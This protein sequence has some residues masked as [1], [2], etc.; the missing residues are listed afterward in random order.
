[1]LVN[2]VFFWRNTEIKA[3]KTCILNFKYKCLILQC[4][5]SWMMLE[6]QGLWIDGTPSRWVLLA[7]TFNFYLLTTLLS[8]YSK[9]PIKL[10]LLKL[11]CIHSLVSCEWYFGEL[12]YIS[13]NFYRKGNPPRV[14]ENSAFMI[15]P[16]E[17][18]CTMC[19][20]TGTMQVSTVPPY[21]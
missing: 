2:C 9:M 7:G 17:L 21:L 6:F 10:P 1:M 4:F 8:A 16:A 20:L 3:T 5:S 13:F 15:T 11:C 14:R 18:Y 12:P 19:D